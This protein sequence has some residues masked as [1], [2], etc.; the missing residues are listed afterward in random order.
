MLLRISFKFT[1]VTLVVLPNP[2]TYWTDG[3]PHP[4]NRANN[5]HYGLYNL[6]RNDNTECTSC[7]RYRS[8]LVQYTYSQWL[9]NHQLWIKVRTNQ[10]IVSKN[11]IFCDTFTKTF[12]Y[13]NGFTVSKYIFHN[14]APLKS[15]WGKPQ[16]GSCPWDIKGRLQNASC[17]RAPLLLTWFNF[18]PSM[19]KYLCPL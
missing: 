18:N 7:R 6:W 2:L 19:D 5:W 14:L 3:T 13:N 15:Q 9:W 8:T 12:L 11:K 4:V 10:S 1:R 16:I 17:H